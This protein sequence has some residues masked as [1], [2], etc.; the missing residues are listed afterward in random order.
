MGTPPPSVI[1]MGGKGINGRPPPIGY[2]DIWGGGGISGDPPPLVP[3]VFGGGSLVPRLWGEMGGGQNGNPPL[4]YSGMGN[5]R[6]GGT[7]G[8]PQCWGG[9]RGEEGGGGIS[10]EPPHRAAPPHKLLPSPPSPSPQSILSA[11]IFPSCTARSQWRFRSGA[12]V[13]NGEARGGRGGGGEGAALRMRGVCG[14]GWG[15]V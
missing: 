8:C 2:G 10:Q 13:C 1:E 12:I 9:R 6:G 11:G 7:P 15:G 5:K 4:I 14:G 3:G